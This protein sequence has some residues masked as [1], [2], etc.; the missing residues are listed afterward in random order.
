MTVDPPAGVPGNDAPG[1]VPGIDVPRLTAWLRRALPGAGGVGGIELIAG[2]RSNLTYRVDLAGADGV[3]GRRVVVRRP[4]LGHVLPTAHDMAREHRVLSALADS[5]VPVPRPLAMCTDEDVI[6]APFYVM[7]Y[8]EGRVLRTVEDAAD[9]TPAQARALAVRLMDV[10]ADIHLLDVGAAGL[11]GF[12]RPDGYLTRQLRR[13][14][15]QWEA[16]KSRELPELDRLL[17][18]LAA[19]R[20][21][22]AHRS[23]VHGDY[24]LDNA[25]LHPARPGEIVAVLDWELSALGDPLADL[26]ALL[27]YW[28]EADDDDV[29][30]AARVV[31][32]LTAAGGFPTRAELV[33]R[34]AERTGFDLSA[35]GWYVAFSYLK[36]AIICQGIADRVAHGA[37]VGDGFEEADARVDAL[38]AA[39]SRVLAT[40]VIT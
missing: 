36:I 33:E 25:V 31:P 1:N 5:A 39:G 13:W 34:Y 23:L 18:D 27:A 16:S 35:L 12:G 29:L 17:A 26:G 22:S 37:M 24:R 15:K 3:P 28:S 9:V 6:G 40:P 4:P 11:A 20:P 38:V 8:V 7:E 2:G 32:P 10:M 21:P 19:T 14:G 30:V